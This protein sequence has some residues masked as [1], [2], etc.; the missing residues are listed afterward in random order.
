MNK[1]FYIIFSLLF[2]ALFSCEKESDETI[3]VL[4]IEPLEYFPAYP[5]SYW[6]YSNNDT[7]KVADEYK[8]Y[9]YQVY[10]NG[11]TNKTGL[12]PQLILNGIYNK[13]ASIAYVNEYSISAREYWHDAPFPFIS[14]LSPT[15]GKIFFSYNMDSHSLIGQTVIIDTSITINNVLY[16]DVIVTLYYDGHFIGTREEIADKKEYYAKDIGLIKRET[17]DF[18]NDTLFTTDFYLISYHVNN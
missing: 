7:L 14:I 16:D 15:K 18:P 10:E 13:G 11:L 2:I 5:G 3:G 4:P 17:R 12:F 6:V 1:Y 9:T 8:S